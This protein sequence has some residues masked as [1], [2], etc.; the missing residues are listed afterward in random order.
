MIN[1]RLVVLGLWKLFC[2]VLRWRQLLNLRRHRLI[3]LFTRACILWGKTTGRVQIWGFHYLWGCSIPFTNHAGRPASFLS[4]CVVIWV[5]EE[6][7][8][9]IEWDRVIIYLDG[10]SCSLDYLLCGV[11]IVIAKIDRLSF[12]FSLHISCQISVIFPL[13]SL[14]LLQL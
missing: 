3:L 9:W 11:K 2:Y 7:A 5:F 12:V 10:R 6:G 14:H 8:H 4:T 13:I 1:K